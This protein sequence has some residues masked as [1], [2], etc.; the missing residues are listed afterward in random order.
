MGGLGQLEE[1]ISPS[2]FRDCPHRR[3]APE[4]LAATMTLL[5]DRLH[6]REDPVLGES[7]DGRALRTS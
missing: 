1:G 4:T 7:V 5:F 6:I 2:E 3:T